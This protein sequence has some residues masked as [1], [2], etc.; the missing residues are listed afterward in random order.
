MTCTHRPAPTI[1]ARAL[2]TGDPK[3]CARFY[4][5]FV[6]DFG[7]CY[8]RLAGYYRGTRESNIKALRIGRAN[9]MRYRPASVTPAALAK[10]FASAIR[11]QL[12][13]AQFTEMQRRNAS[14]V[15]PAG[16]CASHDFCDANMVMYEA[17]CEL[18]GEYLPADIV[19][20]D[21]DALWNPAWNIARRDYLT[22]GAA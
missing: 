15:L 12:T 17:L 8:T 2:W 18:A 22:T 10:A 19:C 4:W 14:P 13:P 21:P 7:G 20:S 16:A 3:E 5:Q 11:A 9:A 1:D 6:H